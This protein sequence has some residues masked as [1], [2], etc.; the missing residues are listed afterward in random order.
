[1]RIGIESRPSDNLY[2]SCPPHRK[3]SSD[4]PATLL[5]DLP[6]IKSPDITGLFIFKLVEAAG[7][8]P[9]FRTLT[10]CYHSSIFKIFLSSDAPATVRN[11]NFLSAVR[12]SLPCS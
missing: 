1:M 8:E 2:F 6:K 11:D 7:I 10:H 9:A 4:G 5:L 3:L 12:A